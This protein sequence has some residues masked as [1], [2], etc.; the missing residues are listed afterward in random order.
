MPVT[1]INGTPISYSTA[2]EGEPLVLV[3]GSWGDG[4]W[5]FVLPKLAES[6]SVVT[7]DRRGHG[8]SRLDQR[9]AGT[10]HDDVADLAALID[11]LGIA[12]ANVLAS[13]FGG[14]IA[15]RAAT[16]HP[17]LVRRVLA[18]EPPA[19]GILSNAGEVGSI[20]DDFRES[21]VWVREL[22]EAGSHR[23]AAKCFFD[24]VAVGPG[25]WQLTPEADQDVFERH[26]PTFLGELRDPDARHLDVDALAAIQMPVLLS[27]GDA[28]LPIFDAVMD[29]LTSAMPNA[30]FRTIRSCGHV[31]HVTNPD[32]YV[33]M[34][35]DFVNASAQ[36]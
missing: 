11:A 16:E 25:T 1:T 4:S 8:E 21:L 2:G 33:A 20:R 10:V 15:L 3:H 29:E 34:V 19:D 7:Y 32:A 31:P 6:F 9:E 28:S 14:C 12:P 23:A 35:V 18:H 27:R 36:A 24:T 13:S 22:I 26:A 17:E 30:T 5:P